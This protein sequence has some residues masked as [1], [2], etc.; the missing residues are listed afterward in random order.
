MKK[1]ILLVLI[2]TSCNYQKRTQVVTNCV[3][4]K[5][6]TTHASTIEPSPVYKLITDCG[7][8]ITI[9][10]NIHKVGDTIITH[11]YHYQND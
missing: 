5:I 8:T 7:D 11:T 1:F 3:I 4:T 2:I 9:S 10:R 6:E